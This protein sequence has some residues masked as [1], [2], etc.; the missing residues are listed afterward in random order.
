MKLHPPPPPP[1]T[2]LRGYDYVASYSITVISSCWQIYNEQPSPIIP[3]VNFYSGLTTFCSCSVLS[4]IHL[5]STEVIGEA[6][7]INLIT[8]RRIASDPDMMALFS[9]RLVQILIFWRSKVKEV[10][11]DTNQ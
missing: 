4:P 10:S 8:I 11:R 6:E 9:P 1:T 2:L 7:A 5:A 3:L